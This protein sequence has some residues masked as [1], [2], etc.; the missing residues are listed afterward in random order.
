[1]KGVARETRRRRIELETGALHYWTRDVSFGKHLNFGKSHLSTN[2]EISHWLL[3]ASECRNG[4]TPR[5]ERKDEEVLRV[6]GFVS[7]LLFSNA[8]I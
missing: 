8:G 3:E 4:L 2:L 7:C 5:V 6:L 1:M